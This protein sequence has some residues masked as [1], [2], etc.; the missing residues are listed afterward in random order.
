MLVEEADELLEGISVE[1]VMKSGLSTTSKLRMLES[2]IT[3]AT[4]RNDRG[5]IE[6][7]Y[8]AKIELYERQVRQ[9]SET[10]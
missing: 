2:L 4:G 1:A 7:A 6:G 5:E 8:R 10:T 9:R 3:A